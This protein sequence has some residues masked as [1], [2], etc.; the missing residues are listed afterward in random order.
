LK[1]LNGKV[2]VITGAGSGIGRA[3][4]KSICKEKTDIALIDVDTAGMEETKRQIDLAGYGN[5]VE[6][7]KLDISNRED[8]QNT[9]N[10]IF[11]SFQAVDIL[12]NNAGVASSGDILDLN[13]KTF[14]WTMNI[15][16][17][18]TIYMTNAFLP[19]LLKQE[20]ASIVNVS[21][22]YGLMGMPFHAAYCTS[23]FAVRGFSEVLRQEL[24]GSGVSV[25]IVFPGGIK[26]NIARNARSDINI[27][28]KL[29]EKGVE[30]EEKSFKTSPEVAAKKIITGIKK[31][32][33][34]IYIGGDAVKVNMLTRFAPGLCDRSIAR[35]IKKSFS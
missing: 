25:S 6:T 19:F 12:I 23:K 35:Y 4:A 8:V 1:N 32:T 34:R 14:D 22:V 28:Q 26:T 5:R 33:P 20:E 10:E 11:S 13:F 21:S 30:V 18:G 9:S 3:L 24:Y 27:D 17:F 16:L 2:V 15:N 7:Y 31:K 29:L